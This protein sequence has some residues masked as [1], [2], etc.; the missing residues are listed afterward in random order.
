MQ[1]FDIWLVSPRASIVNQQ[2]H[3]SY[4]GRMIK[5]QHL[6]IESQLREWKAASKTSLLDQLAALESNEYDALDVP[7]THCDRTILQE[8]TLEWIHFGD[9]R[10]LI[11]DFENLKARTLM[12]VTSKKSQL[13]AQF[14]RKEKKEQQHESRFIKSTYFRKH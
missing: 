4:S 7:T 8:G 6:T 9:Y 3:I 10:T 5:L 1:I 12:I 2:I 13:A 14:E 11:Q